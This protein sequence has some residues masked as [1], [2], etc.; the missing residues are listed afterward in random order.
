MRPRVKNNRTAFKAFICQLCKRLLKEFFPK[1]SFTV[2]WLSAVPLHQKF[3]ERFTHDNSAATFLRNWSWPLCCRALTTATPSSS[4]SRR[5]HWHHYR[6]LHAATRFVLDLKPRDHVTPALREL[7][8]LPVVQRIEYK[9]CLL[10]H[11]ALIGRAPDYI[12][13]L[14]TLVTNIPSRSSL[15]ASSNGDLFQPRI[16]RRIGDRAILCRHTSCMESP[17]DRTETHSV[18]DRTVSAVRHSKAHPVP[19][20]CW[21]WMNSI[22]HIENCSSPNFFFFGFPNA[23]AL[24]SFVSS[25]IQLLKQV[26]HASRNL[27]LFRVL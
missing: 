26:C 2:E 8:W 24:T 4:A 6:V 16:E 12:T 13:N 14:L 23:K 19:H 5:R 17:T 11:K 1:E 9:L 10:V 22:R 15:R 3:S 21:V 25:P 18:V 7:H 20:C 27:V